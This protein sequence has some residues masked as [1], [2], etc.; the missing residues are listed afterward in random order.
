MSN[1][2]VA[3]ITGSLRQG[4]FTRK[5]GRAI[6]ALPSSGM[7][8]SILEIGELPHY[9]EDLEESPPPAFTRFRAAI[10]ASD[11]ALFVTPEFNRSIPG[12]LK[13]ALD[14]GS[15]P[16]GKSVWNGKP[17]A[18][19]SMSYGALAGFG[20]HHHLRQ[21][22]MAVNMPTMPHPEA[23][24]GNAASLFDEG[25]QLIDRSTAAFVTG[26]LDAFH[27]WIDQQRPRSR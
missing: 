23:Y 6:T 22:L 2:E 14:V 4:S 15:R 11:A 12:V 24:I 3:I 19:I 16:W 10:A 27:A 21:V 1:I 7:R 20:A 13:N 5:M 9:N 25:G 17:A 18:V 8:F 26:F